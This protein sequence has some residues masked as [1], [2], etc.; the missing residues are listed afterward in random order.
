MIERTIV[1]E[2]VYRHRPRYCLLVFGPEART[3]VWLVLAGDRL[4]VDRNGNGDL[5]EGGECVRKEATPWDGRITVDFTVGSICAAGGESVYRGIALQEIVEDG[6]PMAFVFARHRGRRCYTGRD[7]SGR[8]RFGATPG[9]APIVHIGGPLRMGLATRE[10]SAP[11]RFVRG[12]VTE[13]CASVGTPGL[14]AGTFLALRYVHVPAD[15]HP[16]A[17]V[18]FP[19]RGAGGPPIQVRVALRERC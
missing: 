15:K 6:G 11:V 5:T 7:A 18:E 17:E 4:Y 1:R 12:A 14:G 19:R 8:L 16:V 10:R 13:L 3:R 9:A 2:P